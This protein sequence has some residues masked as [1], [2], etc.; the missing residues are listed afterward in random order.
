MKNYVLN[1]GYGNTRFYFDKAS[2]D[3]IFAKKKTFID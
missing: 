2:K 1:E 3:K